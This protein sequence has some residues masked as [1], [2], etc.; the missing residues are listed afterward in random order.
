MILLALVLGSR[1]AR[2][3]PTITFFRAAFLIFVSSFIFIGP[4][5]YVTFKQKHPLLARLCL[6]QMTSFTTAWFAGGL[7]S[8][9]LN[10]HGYP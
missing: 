3:D 9:Y 8:P 5:I 1:V 10:S 2:S 6:Y 4:F 7:I